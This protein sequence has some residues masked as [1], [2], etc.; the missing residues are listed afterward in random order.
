MVP[1]VA[2]MQDL[3]SNLNMD[4]YE[5]IIISD[6]NSVFIQHIVDSAGLSDIISTTYTNPAYFDERGCLN[7]DFYHK[8]TWC[9]ISTVNLCKGQILE[10]H[11]AEA[12]NRGVQY[13]TVG[14]IGDGCHDLCPCLKLC[15]TD[16]CYPRT[17]FGLVKKIKELPGQKLSAHVEEWTDGK[18]LAKKIST[19]GSFYM[20]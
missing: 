1:W 17:G 13:S 3:L 5:I 7:I 20:K 2:G 10:A 14:Y 12:G 18:D 15:S 9:D 11:I 19:N 16:I 6:S 8:Q 4:Q